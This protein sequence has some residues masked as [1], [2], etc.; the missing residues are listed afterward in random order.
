[1]GQIQKNGYEVVLGKDSY[2]RH[3]TT[4]VHTEVYERG[5]VSIVPIWINGI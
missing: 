1:M 5:G 3:T 4:D 2:I